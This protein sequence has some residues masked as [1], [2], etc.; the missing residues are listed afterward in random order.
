METAVL[1]RSSGLRVSWLCARIA[2]SVGGLHQ[3]TSVA[4]ALA[5]HPGLKDTGLAAERLGTHMCGGTLV[6]KFT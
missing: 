1:G 3:L 5:M 2:F 4:D 6:N